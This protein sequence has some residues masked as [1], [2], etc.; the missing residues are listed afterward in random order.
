MPFENLSIDTLANIYIGLLGLAVLL[1]AVLD[2]YDLGVGLLIP[3]REERFRDDMIASIGPYWDANETWLVLAVGLLLFAFP[4]AHSDILQTLYLPATFMLVGLI[5]R[6]VSFDFR[7]KVAQVKKRKWDLTFKY[8]SLLT[9]LAQGYMLGIW[10]TGLRTDWAAQ[11]FALLSALGVTAAYAFIGAC[12]LILKS[13]GELQQKA[14]YWARRG[15]GILAGG[16][17]AVSL[18][19]LFLHEEVRNLWLSAPW[20][21]VLMAIPIAC[22]ALLG[23]CAVV[24]KRL[25]AAE[26]RGEW[27]PFG[28]ALLVFVLCFGAFGVSYYPFVVPGE[29]TIMDAVADANSLRFLLVGASIVVPCILAYTFMVYRIFAGKSEKLSYY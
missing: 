9:T 23:L 24:L 15:L 2:G 19:N 3:P 26:G 18:A 22:F 1:Y 13:E 6:G 28:I 20:G 8:G 27:L 4:E 12:W 21:Y 14:F 29:L 17:I 10:V 7:A 11:G 16:I 5:L 25:P